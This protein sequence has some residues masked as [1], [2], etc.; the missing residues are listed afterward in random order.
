MVISSSS[1]SLRTRFLNLDSFRNSTRLWV[2]L[3]TPLLLLLCGFLNILA[4]ANDI[5]KQSHP[6]AT[7]Y[8]GCQVMPPD[9]SGPQCGR[10]G[11]GSNQHYFGSVCYLSAAASGD[12]VAQTKVAHKQ[13]NK[14][15]KQK[16]CFLVDSKPGRSFPTAAALVTEKSARVWKKHTCKQALSVFMFVFFMVFFFWNIQVRSSTVLSIWRCCLL[17][18]ASPSCRTWTPPTC[19]WLAACGRTWGATSTCGRGEEAEHD[20]TLMVSQQFSGPMF[21]FTAS[22]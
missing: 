15:D 4:H 10:T 1:S 22:C 11:D 16:N 20:L 18:W 9:S 7:A 19:A 3:K 21:Y 8:A 5:L 13:S 17:S 14:R 12:Q 2:S 6:H